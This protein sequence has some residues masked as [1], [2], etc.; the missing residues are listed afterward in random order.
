MPSLRKVEI[1]GFVDMLCR[2]TS[3]VVSGSRASRGEPL[4][5]K[6]GQAIKL[7]GRCREATFRQRWAAG[8][9]QKGSLHFRGP[10]CTVIG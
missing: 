4:H 8:V 10:H 3:A 5:V 1:S 6:D 2:S 9:R 7:L